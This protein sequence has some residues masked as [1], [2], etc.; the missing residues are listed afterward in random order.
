VFF[1]VIALVQFDIEKKSNSTL[2][3]PQKVQIKGKAATK[4]HKNIRK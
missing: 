3:D 4:T 2:K 1:P